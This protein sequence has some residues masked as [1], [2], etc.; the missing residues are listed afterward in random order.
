MGSASLGPLAGDFL[1]ILAF[2]FVRVYV[3]NSFF[4]KFVHFLEFWIVIKTRKRK[5]VAELDFLENFFFFCSEV[6]FLAQNRVFLSF[7]KILSLL[8]PGSSIKWGVHTFICFLAWTQCL[9]K[10]CCTT[11]RPKCSCPIRLQ[12]SL[13]A[14]T[15]KF[16]TKYK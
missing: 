1:W 16:T 9:G 5:K 3:G 10:F 14:A 11:L 12:D 2:P 4:S 13:S 15:Y 6:P 8:F 7:Y